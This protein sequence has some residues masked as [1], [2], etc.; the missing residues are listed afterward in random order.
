MSATRLE[1]RSLIVDTYSIWRNKLNAKKIITALSLF[2]LSLSAIA[3]DNE[4]KADANRALVIKVM[5][6]TFVNR[7]TSMVASQ[8]ASNYIQHNPRIPNG[9]D[10]I[11]PLISGLPKD[12]RY[13][14]GT[15]V[16]QGD[17][18]MV[19]GRYTGWGP[20]PVIAVDIFRVADGKLAEH[21]DVLQPEVPAASSANGNPMFVAP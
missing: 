12:F 3:S 17:F 20:K 8:F 1:S 18:V 9:R 10:A 11:P 6:T 16:A 5:Q 2:A 19:H 4:S 21:W 14:M 13:E 15:V 7:D